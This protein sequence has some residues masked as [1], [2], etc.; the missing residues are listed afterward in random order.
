MNKELHPKMWS[1]NKLKDEV[2]KNLLK[3]AK[4][5]LD[6]TKL[7]TLKIYDIIIT[8]SMA[9]YNWHEKSDI[10]LHVV[11]DLSKFDKNKNFIIEYL[12]SKKSLWNSIHQITMYN[13]PVEIYPDEKSNK[14]I[15]S[16][17]YSLLKN[18][19]VV[20]PV[21]KEKQIDKDLIKKKYQDEVDKILKFE[22]EAKSKN[23]DYDTLIDNISKYKDDLRDKRQ[24]GLNSDGE[25]SV[26]NLV[27]KLLRNNGF[28]EKL[29][30]LKRELYDK[31]LTVEKTDINENRFLFNKDLNSYMGWGKC[32]KK[33]KAKKENGEKIE[34]KENQK[35]GIYESNNIYWTADSP[36]GNGKILIQK[37]VVDF[38]RFEPGK[39][40]QFL[41]KD[42]R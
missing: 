22:K 15:S 26:Y 29:I 10:D 28:I 20:K 7:K 6:Y 5:F 23:P 9:N 30:N 13:H 21:Y 24:A 17:V 40:S 34:I 8:G 33:T 19:W 4:D 1:D 37:S 2:R 27:F 41:I 18:K 11:F 3:I 38:F 42:K 39:M 35:M 25:F 12:K 16:G 32:I 36:D 31:S 14:H